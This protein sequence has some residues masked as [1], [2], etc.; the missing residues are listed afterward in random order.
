[1]C[2]CV[3]ACVRRAVC[4][5][6]AGH[7]TPDAGPCPSH[8]RRRQTNLA[9]TAAVPGNHSLATG[10]NRGLVVVKRDY[11]LLREWAMAS[12]KLCYLES[13]FLMHMHLLCVWCDRTVTSTTFRYYPRIF[14]SSLKWNVFPVRLLW[15][16]WV[17]GRSH[18]RE[19]I[20]AES[21]SHLHQSVHELVAWGESTASDM[22]RA[23]AEEHAFQFTPGGRLEHRFLDMRIWLVLQTDLLRS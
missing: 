17:D 18:H 10:L 6:D 22:K 16:P 4:D 15:C 5:N 12:N 19:R 3:C 20:I 13:L 14:A 23:I 9:I 7:P 21:H 8:H 2:V 11:V 1:M